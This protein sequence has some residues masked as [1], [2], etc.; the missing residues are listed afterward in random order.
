MNNSHLR[1]ALITG[2]DIPIPEYQLILHQP[3]IKE[4]SMLGEQAFFTGAQLLCFDAER[5]FQNQAIN[6]DLSDFQL[7]LEALKIDGSKKQ[8]IA[9]VLKLLFPTYDALF[10]PRSIILKRETELITIDEEDFN[11][12]KNIFSTI[13]CFNGQMQD[14]FNPAKGKAEEIARKL[15]RAR[16]RVAA[17]KQQD[18]QP[19]LDQYISS[20]VVGIQSM[21]LFDVINL[22]LYQLYDLL[23]R[24]GMYS[25]YD[26]DIKARLAGS[27]GDKEIENWMKSIH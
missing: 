21:S 17:Q 3:T 11:F 4:I 7:L 16:Q 12:F 26:L 1:L 27:T 6:T 15:L 14:S 9:N 18:A 20:L 13:F 23:Q 22:T 10:T 8:S 25:N 24:Y 2:V 5:F 19:S